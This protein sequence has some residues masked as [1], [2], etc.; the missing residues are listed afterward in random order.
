MGVQH[1]IV[2]ELQLYVR[3]ISDEEYVTGMFPVPLANIGVLGHF[4]NPRTYGLRATYNF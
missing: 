2:L 1:G 4:G 3:N